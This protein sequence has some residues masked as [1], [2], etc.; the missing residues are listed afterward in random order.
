MSEELDKLGR[1]VAIGVIGSTVRGVEPLTFDMT[2]M[3]VAMTMSQGV[4]GALMIV[5]GI[6]KDPNGMLDIILLDGLGIRGILLYTLYNEGCDRDPVKFSLILK[7]IRC[8][9]FTREQIHNNLKRVHVLHFIDDAV[10][11]EG[12]RPFMEC[13]GPGHELWYEWC[14]AQIESFKRRGAT[15]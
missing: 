14:D 1:H 6:L 11:V 10:Q 7:M 9:A 5:M 2:M 8:N 15:L 4:L 12:V 3:E 13:F